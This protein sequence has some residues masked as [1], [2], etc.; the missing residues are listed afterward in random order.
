VYARIID[1]VIVTAEPIRENE[2]RTRIPERLDH[3]E[4]AV[5]AAGVEPGRVVSHLEKEDL[6]YLEGG[7]NRAR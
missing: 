3:A 2:V 5:P 6:V 7:W 1:A 4:Q